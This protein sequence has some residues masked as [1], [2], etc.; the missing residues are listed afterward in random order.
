MPAPHPHTLTPPFYRTVKFLH[1]SRLP[2]LLTRDYR[3][4]GINGGE[5]IRVAYW[6]FKYE[7]V[8]RSFRPSEF[9]AKSAKMNIKSRGCRT[10]P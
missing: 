5:L 1:G 4:Y 10:G 2:S 6:R 3:L 8:A 7:F 9:P